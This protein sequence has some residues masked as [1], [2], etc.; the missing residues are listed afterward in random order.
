M[1]DSHSPC[2]FCI[3]CGNQLTIKYEIFKTASPHEDQAPFIKR[4]TFENFQNKQ[5][6]KQKIVNLE[7]SL[8]GHH[9]I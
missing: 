2:S 3:L 4:H 9:F 6:N 8:E 1:G 7:K 5:A